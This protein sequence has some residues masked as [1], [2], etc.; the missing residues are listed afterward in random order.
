MRAA[1]DAS[2]AALRTQGLCKH[3]GSGEALVR[4]VDEFDLVVSVG[5]TVA[6]TGPSGCGKSTLLHLLAGLERPSSGTVW[7]G[8][9]RVDDLSERAKA[10][11]RR[12]SVGIVFQSFELMAELTAIE[13]IELPALLA[14]SGRREAR[15]RAVGLLDEL[16]VGDI[17]DRQPG[18]MSGGQR[19]RVA[20]ARAL[21]NGP[22]LL[23]A[24]EPTG[25]LDGESTRDVLELFAAL[26]ARGQ[27]L[28]VVTHDPR[29]AAT[30]D[31]VIAMRDGRPVDEQVLGTATA[32]GLDLLT[33]WGA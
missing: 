11:L 26:H 12:E 15:R 28:L 19:Q 21:V 8:D 4:A 17:Q 25:N 27:T 7:I 24:D 33:G 6:V 22:D 2:A 10:R 18:A 20:V 14:G 3:F 5:E 30:A 16:G 23:L 32:G 31:R 29:V 9:R 13:N 1:S